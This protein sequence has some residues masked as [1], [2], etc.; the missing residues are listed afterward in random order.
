MIDLRLGDY[1]ETLADVTCDLLCVDAPYSA[2]T[3]G[4]H[5]AGTRSD[6][7]GDGYGHRRQTRAINY[8]GWEPD[9][10][11]ECVEFFA[12]RTRGWMVSITDHVLAPV[13]ADAMESVGLYAFAPIPLVE[14]GSRVRLS[15]D[16]P[17]SWTCWII[18][19]RPR[20]GNDRTGRPYSKW[21]TLRGAYVYTGRGD[22]TVM[23]GKTS[24]SMTDMINDYSRPGD[25]VC[26][27]CAGGGTTLLAARKLGRDAIGSELDPETHH[28]ASMRLGLVEDVDG[29]PLFA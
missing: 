3:H 20:T 13:W 9:D 23:G 11:R 5:D 1:R 28:K 10:V 2:R 12:P 4:G 25:T 15:G 19:A 29:L 14:I 21:G 24:W 17:S 18:A 7:S 8:A 22:R 16:G 26:D 6:D 27:P